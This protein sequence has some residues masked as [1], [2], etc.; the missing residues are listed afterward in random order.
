MSRGEQQGHPARGD[1]FLAN[2]NPTV[3]SEQR[4][5]RPVV[6]LQNDRGNSRSSTVIVAPLTSR[7]KRPELPTHVLLPDGL[8]LLEQ[9]RT[10]DRKRLKEKIGRLDRATLARVDAALRASLGLTTGRDNSNEAPR[11]DGEE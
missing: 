2:L 11:E 10:I 5:V 8:I 3:G 9:L 1:I 7:R 6:V 4:G